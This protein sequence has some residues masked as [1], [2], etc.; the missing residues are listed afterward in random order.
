MIA[1]LGS[2][3]YIG[4][5]L[6]RLIAQ[7]EEQRL[8]LF[9]RDLTKITLEAWPSNVSHSSL[10]K[11]DAGRFD[12]VINAIGVGD[13]S[14]VATT[15]TNIFELTRVWDQCILST[16]GTQT[17]YVYI[18]SGAVYGSCLKQAVDENSIVSLPINQ[19]V[20]ASPYTLSKICAE[21]GH[22]YASDRAILDI[23]VFGYSDPS[24]S[25]S[26]SFFLSHLA[27]SVA[28]KCPLVTSHD[29]MVRDYAGVSELH[30][31]I[32][33]WLN[34]KSPNRAFDLY[35]RSP[36][37]KLNLLDLVAKRYGVKIS[38]S[39]QIEST[40]PTKKTVYSSK[41]YAASEVGYTPWRTST[42][43][44]LDTLDSIVRR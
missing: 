3:G 33:S 9:A 40:R 1:I 31:L 24:I 11:F 35:T 42:E 19:L 6:A 32:M 23:R 43:V 14:R 27:R 22:R 7:N 10:E 39:K 25:Q 44:I 16:M 21:A 29:D 41:Y 37:S 12:L 17:K 13:P 30:A 38:Y 8:T 34:S 5:S 20:L 28:T 36:V 4:C 2:T 18:S 15:G 26:G